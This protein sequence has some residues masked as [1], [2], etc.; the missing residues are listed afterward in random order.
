MKRIKNYIV[1]LIIILIYVAINQIF[2]IYI[3]CPIFSV[4]GL[5]CPGCGVTRM[6]Y[7][8]FKLDFY[9]AFRYNPLLFISLPFFI[10]FIVNDI[11]SKIKN[12]ES[13]YKKVPEYIWIIVIFIFMIFGILRNIF[14][15]LAP[16][17][18]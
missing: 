8:I 13:L 9:Q 16:T 7:S 6:I 5:Y 3:P 14:P 4:T 18:I 15:Y 11:Y 1:L 2:D 17:E 10:F 12:K